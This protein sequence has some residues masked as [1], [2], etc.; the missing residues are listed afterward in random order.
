MGVFVNYEYPKKWEKSESISKNIFDWI[1]TVQPVH[2]C[3]PDTFVSILRPGHV[4]RRERMKKL[5]ECILVVDSVFQLHRIRQIQ[6][7]QIE[8][9]KTLAYGYVNALVNDEYDPYKFLA[10][11]GAPAIYS[12]PAPV[13]KF[14]EEKKNSLT[15]VIGQNDDM[16]ALNDIS[17]RLAKDS[18]DL[19]SKSRGIGYGPDEILQTNRQ[20]FNILGPHLGSHYG[21]IVIVFRRE[22][23]HHSDAN[24]SI[25]SATSYHSGNAFQWRPCLGKNPGAQNE[26]VQLFH[27]SKLLASV[28]GYEYTTALELITQTS[29]V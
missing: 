6:A 21:N 13:L 24:F 18:H 7:L 26:R 11:N 20:V 2:R 27:S 17:I 28:P 8:Y 12:T 14:T 5:D 9:Y 25:Q 3:L 29:H 15:A 10:V 4:M 23:L 22:V 19:H 1:R 16:K